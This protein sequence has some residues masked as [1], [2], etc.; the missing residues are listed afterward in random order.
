MKKLISILMVALMALPLYSNEPEYIS[1]GE[2]YN[3]VVINI[4][5]SI[6]I[7]RDVEHSVSITNE[8]R[9][10]ITYKISNDT[11]FIKSKKIL[12]EN[13]MD[14]SRLKIHLCHP[15]PKL[16]LNNINIPRSLG[17]TKNKVKSGNQN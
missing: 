4:P 8:S 7:S 17:A 6:T 15:N 14:A 11:L 10:N 1:N 13:E 16:I 2:Q 5:A 9:G 12:T 3:T